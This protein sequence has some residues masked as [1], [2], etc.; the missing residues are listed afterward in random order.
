M[1]GTDLQVNI[2]AKHR[3]AIDKV[4]KPLSP[5][6]DSKIGKCFCA[7]ILPAEFTASNWPGTWF[8]LNKLLMLNLTDP[9]PPRLGL[10]SVNSNN[11]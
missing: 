5:K 10:T 1:E 3:R 6:K 7:V 4:F 11:L 2:S 9:I 8:S